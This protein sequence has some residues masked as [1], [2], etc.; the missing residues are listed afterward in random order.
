MTILYTDY[1]VHSVSIPE[2]G[3]QHVRATPPADGDRSPMAVECSACEPYLR[4]MGWVEQPHYQSY[5]RRPDGTLEPQGK[6]I[7]LT[8]EMLEEIQ[9]REDEASAAV[10]H[11][12][13]QLVGAANTMLAQQPTTRRRARR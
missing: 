11:M 7:P 4:K 8:D 13:E 9:Q 5:R 6:G 12:G 1:R 2:T 3:H 10:R